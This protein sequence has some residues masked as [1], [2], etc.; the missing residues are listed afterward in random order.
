MNMVLDLHNLPLLQ[1][2]LINQGLETWLLAGKRLWN[3]EYE[4][5]FSL[6]QFPEQDDG[7][8]SRCCETLYVATLFGHYL[9]W[10]ESCMN[11]IEVDVFLTFSSNSRLIIS[12]KPL[13]FNDLWGCYSL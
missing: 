2:V 8:F 10:T 1:I 12:L 13:I 7:T 5:S 3:L 4:V 11:I 9:N 6:S